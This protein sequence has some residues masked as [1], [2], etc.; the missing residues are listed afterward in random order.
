MSQFGVDIALVTELKTGAGTVKENSD[1]EPRDFDQQSEVVT[2]V[3]SYAGG[4]WTMLGFAAG[5][6]T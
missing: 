4:K 1:S 2:F 6:Q 3:A 5:D